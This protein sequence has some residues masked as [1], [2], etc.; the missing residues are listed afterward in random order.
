MDGEAEYIVARSLPAE[1][2]ARQQ[3]PVVQ[4]RVGGIR[5]ELYGGGLSHATV[6]AADVRA[7]RDAACHEEPGSCRKKKCLFYPGNFK[8]MSE[9]I[10][11]N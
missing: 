5:H 4:C 1:I 8:L 3:L 9:T 7:A 11:L 10:M 6:L 2:V